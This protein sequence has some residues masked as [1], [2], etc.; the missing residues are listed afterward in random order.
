[1]LCHY[2]EVRA[3]HAMTAIEKLQNY[4]Q[5]PHIHS[6]YRAGYCMHVWHFTWSG[7]IVFIHVKSCRESLYLWFFLAVFTDTRISGSL[8]VTT[9]C[10]RHSGWAV[11]VII[12]PRALSWP[13]TFSVVSASFLSATRRSLHSG[14]TAC[15]SQVVFHPGSPSTLTGSL[16]MCAWFSW[17]L[18]RVGTVRIGSVILSSQTRTPSWVVIVL[19]RSFAWYKYHKNG[20]TESKRANKKKLCIFDITKHNL[21]AVGGARV[22]RKWHQKHC[23]GELVC[24][25]K[26][27]AAYSYI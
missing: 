1:M 17:P 18:E 2:N 19:G 3:H 16:F 11:W 20:N 21:I 7:L 26:R 4:D 6:Q 12:N 14:L 13:G 27:G 10:S 8:P 25:F 9:M 24:R 5:D 15:D 22:E 23:S